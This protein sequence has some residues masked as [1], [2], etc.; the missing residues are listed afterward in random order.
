MGKYQG[1]DK[2]KD[3]GVE[4]LGAIPNHWEVIPIKFSLSMPIT[5][6]PHETPDL[7]DDGIPFISAEAIKNDQI[8]FDKKRGYISLEEHKRFSKKY[9]PKYGDVYMV[10]S[11]ATTGNVARV[12]THEEFNI[13]SP[14][15][16]LRPNQEK[17]TTDFL[18]YVIKSKPFFYSVE[19]SWSFGTQQNIGMGII[20]NIR[21]T[22]PPLDEQ[23]KIARFLDYKTKQID[24]LIAKKETLIEKLDEKRT[25]LITHAV[26]KGLDVNVPMKDSGI[27][28][29]GDIPESWKIGKLNYFCEIISGGTPDRN[30]PDFWEGDIPW[31]KTGEVNY[32]NIYSTEE[33]ITKEGLNSSSTTLAKPETLLMAMYGQGNTR[34]RV[35]ILKIEAAFNQACLGIYPLNNLNVYF[36]YYYLISAYKYIRDTGNESSQMNLS[37]G[38]I[39]KISILTP[40]LE[41]QQQIVKFL[42]QKTAQIDEQKTKIQQAI[43]LLKEYRTALIT[44]A[45]TGKIDVRKITIPKI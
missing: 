8:N 26:T 3:S 23:E 14:L 21:I 29:L 40:S 28:W 22:F 24:E 4:W 31:V 7:L 19:Q 33:Y 32:K 34:G 15:A 30:N 10:K 43:D 5:D 39:G 13:W 41:M 44:N 42:D 35:A 6:G 20:A 18:F 25:A 2:Y 45:V 12:Q 38:L 27:E 11:G 17:T 1:Y 37:A 36:L 9:K 16:A